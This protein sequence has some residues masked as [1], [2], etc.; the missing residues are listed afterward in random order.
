[1]G[2]TKYRHHVG[3]VFGHIPRRIPNIKAKLGKFHN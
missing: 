2:K 3:A 1:L